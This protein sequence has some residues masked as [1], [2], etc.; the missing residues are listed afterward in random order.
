VAPGAIVGAEVVA[1]VLCETEKNGTSVEAMYP[2]A[3]LQ[4]RHGRKVPVEK[5]TH[6]SGQSNEATPSAWMWACSTSS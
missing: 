6:E 5:E 2:E 4:A 1:A 3:V